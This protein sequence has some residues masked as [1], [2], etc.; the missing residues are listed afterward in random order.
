MKYRQSWSQKPSL[1]YSKQYLDEKSR[2]ENCLQ[3]HTRNSQQLSAR[4]SNLSKMLDLFCQPRNSIMATF[5]GL[6]QPKSVRSPSLLDD[7]IADK[8]DVVVSDKI[9]LLEMEAG[10]EKL[11]TLGSE[12]KGMAD[13]LIQKVFHFLDSYIIS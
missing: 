2:I 5:S 11:S 9:F 13:H 4:V 7:S 1:V 3:S 10:L 8:E 12:K 6:A